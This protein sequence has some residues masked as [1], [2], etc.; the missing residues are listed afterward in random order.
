MHWVL[1]KLSQGFGKGKPGLTNLLDGADEHI[2]QEQP[3]EEAAM[4]LQSEQVSLP[5]A[6]QEARQPP[7]GRGSLHAWRSTENIGNKR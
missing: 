3:A 1:G 4:D 5:A 2:H 6:L 7:H